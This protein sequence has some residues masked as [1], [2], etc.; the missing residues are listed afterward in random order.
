MRSVVASFSFLLLIF[1]ASAA[2]ESPDTSSA[3]ASRILADVRD[4]GA[5]ATAAA[6]W[7]NQHQ[8][9]EAMEYIGRGKP[10]WLKV[11]VALRP[12]T[13]GGASQNLDEAVFFALKPN[14][15][16]VLRL[17]HA[18]QFQTR[19]V[20]SG[21]I[22]IDYP[23]ERARMLIQDR[24]DVLNGVSDLNLMTVRDECRSSLRAGLK[25]SGS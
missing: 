10:T 8:W 19:S 20:C 25:D 15:I 5:Q 1:F 4:R 6:L 9:K 11:A 16:S 18:E 13:D 24:I 17:L 12:G 3:Q 23:A 21:K 22:A 2:A 7:D 14:P